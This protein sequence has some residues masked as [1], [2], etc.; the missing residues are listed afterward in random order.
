MRVGERIKNTRKENKMTQAELAEKIGVHEVTVR[1]WEN[2]NKSP[3]AAMMPSLASALNTSIAYLLGEKGNLDSD[4][5]AIQPQIM[6]PVIDQEAYAGKG[7]DY[8][9]VVAEAKEWLPWPIDSMGG[10]YE[11][12]KPYFVRVKGDSMEGV[13]I[14]DGC[15]ALVNPNVEVLNGNSAFIEWQGVRSIKGFM[16]YPDGRVELRPANPNYLT[17]HI[18][19]KSASSYNFKVLGKVVRWVNMGI[20]D[21]VL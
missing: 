5:D 4:A 15:M 6:L 8:A 7:F 3:N 16:Q 13:G 18:D 20:P 17:V 9:E 2:T 11:P 21:N 14:N 19:A 1:T 12:K 10:M